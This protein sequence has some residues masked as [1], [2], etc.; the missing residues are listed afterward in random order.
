MIGTPS[1]ICAAAWR[2]E[3]LEAVTLPCK[4]QMN[5]LEKLTNYLKLDKLATDVSAE[6]STLEQML[7]NKLLSY[8]AGEA[9]SFELP[10]NWSRVTPF[11][12]KVLQVVA[13]IPY[14]QIL[15]YGEIA[16]LVGN[17]KGSRAVGGAVGA[18][19]W[20]LVVP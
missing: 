6:N 1:G 4:T 7:E 2:E 3:K 5:A 9:T 20:L 15:S 18:N 8:F 13:N 11:Q 12:Q 17:P 19:P 10:I 14:G 16:K